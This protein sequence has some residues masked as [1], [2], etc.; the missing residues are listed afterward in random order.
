MP[1]FL[2][3]A[4]ASATG[5]QIF[6]Q[7][8]ARCH[9][10]RGE[11]TAA[12]YAEPLTGDRSLTELAEFISKSMPPDAKQKCTENESRLVAAFIFDEFYSKTATSAFAPPRL[13]LN[14]LT[15]RQ[16]RNAVADLMASFRGEAGPWGDQ[17]GLEGSYASVLPNGDGKHIMSRLDPEIRFD[18]GKG[19]PDPEKIEPREF[20]ISW[21]GSLLAPVSGEYEFILRSEN[22]VS[23]WVN[24]RVQ[25]LIDGWVKS[26]D[27]KEYHATVRLLG[28]RR[29]PV[30]LN[31]TKK[32]QGVM[33][34]ADQ[35]A[36]EQIAPAAITL[37]WIP[38]G[39]SEQVIPKEFFS[40]QH[41]PES[42]Y[43]ET[44]FPPDD[45]STGFER[46]TSISKEWDQATTHGALEVADY[47]VLRL[48]DLS[49]GAE[50]GPDYEQRLREFCRQF[51]ER[52]FRGP[53]TAKQKELYVDR[54]FEGATDLEV[55]VQ[56][57]VLMAL[58][59]PRFLYHGIGAQNK[60][61]YRAAARLS[62]ALWDAPPDSVLVAAAAAGN[63]TNR[64]QIAAHAERLS[65]DPRFRFKF[66]EFLLQW[67]KLDQ[68]RDL[69]KA[70][71]Q[72][73]GF[74]VATARDLRLSF[75][76]LL[77]QVIASDN[78][79]FRQL[80]LTNQ[81]ELN[82]RLSKVYGGNLPPDAPFQRVAIETEHCAGILTHPYLMSVFADATTTSPIR[83]GVFLARGVFGRALLPPPDAFVP[84]APALHPNLN[85]R[86]RAAL[87]TKETSCQTC[88]A[89]I[90]PLGFA[91]ENFDAIGRY[92]TEEVA[93]PIDATGEYTTRKGVQVKF[94]GARDLAA[95]VAQSEEAHSA[96]VEKMFHYAV[97]QPVRA[98]G[99]ETSP[100][101]KQ[102]FRDSQFNMRKLL[103]EI[104][105][106]SALAPP[107]APMLPQSASG[108]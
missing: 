42:Y 2:I 69:N 66:R 97:Q 54:P 55:A 30:L 106:E 33:K 103:M 107:L 60:N 10:A 59:S 73:P 44:P 23:L 58:K 67:M 15:T 108:G 100:R 28:G 93:R 105:I 92:R 16:Y 32:G 95:Y 29:Y 65:K 89:M 68:V 27:V 99:T 3:A 61:G 98:L 56:K 37:S 72:F 62:F 39:R 79:D 22:S 87:Q 77:D 76:L 20:A 50:P 49:G 84:L 1:G 101:L 41:Y 6:Q 78:C 19:S 46:G 14:H 38:P 104:G 40:P 8:C 48:R 17:R 9:G 12:H 102:A 57:V 52:A 82:G 5:E 26:G 81:I 53:L 71:D 11:G 80:F 85:T 91:L 83:R 90:N 47:V 34:P 45:R 94:K 18:F 64:E 35:K 21:K 75:E 51:A 24:D 7:R 13:A 36:K 31:F 4:D 86:E 96:F 63:L 88:H 74:D 70:A 25:P 43:V